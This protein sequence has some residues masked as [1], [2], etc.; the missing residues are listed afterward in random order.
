M[1]SD[2]GCGCN[3]SRTTYLLKR[4]RVHD[5]VRLGKRIQ[6][7]QDDVLSERWRG[8][9]TMSNCGHRCKRNRTTYQ[10]EVEKEREGVRL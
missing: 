3:G 2:C 1:V 4:E 6:T 9:M 10:L 8:S 5:S 7:E